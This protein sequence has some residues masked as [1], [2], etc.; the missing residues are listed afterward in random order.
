MSPLV[1]FAWALWE[2]VPVEDTDDDLR[3][4]GDV[5]MCSQQKQMYLYLCIPTAECVCHVLPPACA[6]QTPPLA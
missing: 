1:I 3:A 4:F 5:W 6:T 2:N